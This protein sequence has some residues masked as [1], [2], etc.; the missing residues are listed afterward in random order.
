MS[1]N[2]F[3]KI[4]PFMKWSEKKYG[5]A[6]QATDNTI[7]RMRCACWIFK[8]QTHSE[9]TR[10]IAF[11]RQNGYRTR[12]RLALYAHVLLYKAWWLPLWA[13]ACSWL[14]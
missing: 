9:Y 6:R 4:V 7:Q 11:P 1:N 2:L 5:I 13:E 10:F 8:L 12:L 14:V 3:T